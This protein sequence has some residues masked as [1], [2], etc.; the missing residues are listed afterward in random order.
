MASGKVFAFYG[1]FFPG[2]Y[3]STGNLCCKYAKP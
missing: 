1:A 3:F 2:F